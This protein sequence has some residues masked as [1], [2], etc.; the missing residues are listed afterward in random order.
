MNFA[1]PGQGIKGK[2]DFAHDA[3]LRHLQLRYALLRPMYGAESY[4]HEID[5]WISSD[6]HEPNARARKNVPL[7]ITGEQGSG[8]SSILAHW[9]DFH[10]RSHKKDNDFIVVHYARR[11]PSDRFYY[12]SLHRLFSRLREEFDIKQK[13]PI[14]EDKLR[15]YFSRWLELASAKKESELK[16]KRIILVFDGIERYKD[17]AGKEETPDWIPTESP[18]GVHLIYVVSQESR[19]F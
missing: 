1:E 16:R 14:L 19:S 8:K 6:E 12:Y 15:V 7:I 17:E 18:N 4:I 13:M 2:I 5:S 11:S 10:Q 9:L 3:Y